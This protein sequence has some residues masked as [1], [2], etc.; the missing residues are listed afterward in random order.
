MNPQA[1]VRLIAETLLFL[2]PMPAQDRADRGLLEA[3]QAREAGVLTLACG[4]REWR[5]TIPDV[6]GPRGWS[7]RKSHP[8]CVALVPVLDYCRSAG[9]GALLGAPAQIAGTL[10]WAAASRRNVMCPSAL[11]FS[12]RLD[13][14]SPQSTMPN[15]GRVG[16]R[17]P[18]CMRALPLLGDESLFRLNSKPTRQPGTTTLASLHEAFSANRAWAR[19]EENA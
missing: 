15:R 19:S 16:S 2:S 9:G 14:Q 6:R 3:E 5:C 4:G 13:L 8:G 11:R 7:S 1:I 17:M 12:K 18:I 10:A